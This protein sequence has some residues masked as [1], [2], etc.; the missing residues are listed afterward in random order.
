MSRYIPTTLLLIAIS[1]SLFASESKVSIAFWDVESLYDT[2]P[3]PNYY[4]DDFT[5][6]GRGNWGKERYE[7]KVENIAAVIDSM[8]LPIIILYGVE[9]RGVSGDIVMASQ[10][11]YSFIHKKGNSLNGL[12]FTLL[13]FGD[14]LFIDRVTLRGDMLIVEGEVYG[15]ELTIVAT[16][17]GRYLDEVESI[18]PNSKAVLMGRYTQEQIEHLP[19]SD[20]LV[21]HE[22]RGYGNISTSKGWRV[23][24]RVAVTPSLSGAV[25]GIYIKE[26]LLTRDRVAPLATF[27]GRRY[28]GGYSSH[29]PIFIFF[30]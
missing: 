3:S 28:L 14:I 27:D 4:D 16:T 15:E 10:E 30:E 26:W 18:N 9:S 13:Y 19:L 24:D 8:R 5:P 17:S 11:D 22:K 21:E 25:G 1:L 12:G 7:H 29:L 6:S 2:I 20:L 23:E